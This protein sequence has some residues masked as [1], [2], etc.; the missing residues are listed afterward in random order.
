MLYDQDL[1]RFLWV[2]ACNT[3]VYIQNRTP[4]RALGKKTPKGVFTQKKLEV[5]HLRIFRSV[6]YCHIPDE[7]RSKLD[8]I[9]E[10][11]NLVGYSETRRHTKSTF[12]AAERLS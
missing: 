7:T 3:T 4:H 8:Q 6:A 5:D 2:E 12:Q 1:P 10:K 9:A 11:G